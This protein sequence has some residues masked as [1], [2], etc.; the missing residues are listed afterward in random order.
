MHPT[1]EELKMLMESVGFSNCNFDN[2]TNGIVAIHSGKKGWW[3]LRTIFV[4]SRSYIF[5]KA[6]VDVDIEAF[7]AS[8]Y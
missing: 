8:G 7:N 2:L 4:F 5:L 1:Q 6:R 3:M